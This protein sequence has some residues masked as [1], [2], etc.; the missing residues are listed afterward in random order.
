MFNKSKQFLYSI[1][2]TL[3]SLW[4]EG[5]D[6]QSRSAAP[7]IGETATNALEPI[8]IFTNTLYSICF[9][10]GAAFIM[11]SIV[12]YKEY[13]ENP[14]QTPVSRPIAIFLFGLVLLAIPI[15]A[16]LSEASTAAGG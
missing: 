12:R 1:V 8:N 3:I 13:R 2:F 7:S 15:I 14:S 16:K 4:V 6:A 5:V 11:G 10:L 9:I